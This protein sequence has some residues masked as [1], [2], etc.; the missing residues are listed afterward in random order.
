[1]GIIDSIKTLKEFFAFRK[2]VKDEM[3]DPE[4]EFN[5]FGLSINKFG[6][7]I[8]KQYDF[9]DSDFMSADYND[10]KML[11]TR[12][13]KVLKYFDDM[14]WDNLIMTIQQFYNVDFPTKSFCVTFK[15][16]G[17]NDAVN[18]ILN[19]V[20]KMLSIIFAVCVVG[21]CVYLIYTNL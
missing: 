21:A 9:D 1:M 17:A 16:D 20:L 5:K 6:D 18:G 4:T 7:V 13:T 11:M 8:Y 3:K 10:E 2:E 12:V 19:W 14:G 15:F